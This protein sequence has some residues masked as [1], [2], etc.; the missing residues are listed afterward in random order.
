MDL[1]AQAKTWALGCYFEHEIV[2]RRV[3]N[4][5]YD[6]D[7]LPR[8]SSGS[9][10][11]CAGLTRKLAKPADRQT[12]E[13]PAIT[14]REWYM[15]TSHVHLGKLVWDK[16]EK[17]GCY[18]YRCLELNA[19]DKIVKNAWYLVCFY[20]PFG[21]LV[22]HDPYQTQFDTPR[23]DSQTLIN[24]LCVGQAIIQCVDLGEHC[25]YW[26]SLGHC[27]GEYE[28]YMKENCRKACKLCK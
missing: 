21:N 26:Q 19:M 17:V 2:E 7:I 14:L 1:E 8:R 6:S 23:R 15:V 10:M 9:I 20:T 3:E 13:N 25:D 28:A 18:S 5:A 24:G 12:A 27:K 16:T 22:G 11:P 4:L